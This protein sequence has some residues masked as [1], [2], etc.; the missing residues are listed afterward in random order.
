MAM[1]ERVA[2]VVLMLFPEIERAAGEMT[3]DE[4]EDLAAHLRDAADGFDG[5]AARERVTA[6]G[7]TGAE[8]RA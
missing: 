1:S 5:Q 6:D 4:L 3:P 2:D 8:G 7:M